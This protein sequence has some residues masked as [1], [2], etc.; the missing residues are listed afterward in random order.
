[1]PSIETAVWKN[2]P[3]MIV[4]CHSIRGLPHYKL[5]HDFLHNTNSSYHCVRVPDV[6]NE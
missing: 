6:E 1:M 5:I 2:R 4:T 3:N